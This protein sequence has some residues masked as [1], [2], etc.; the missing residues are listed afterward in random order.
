MQQHTLVEKSTGGT[1]TWRTEV[2]L[3]SEH[4]LHPT[5]PAM[6]TSSLLFIGHRCILRARGLDAILLPGHQS[7]TT[8][9]PH[10]W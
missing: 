9:Q 10:L 5:T 3:H 2:A 6:N 1:P 4:E 7:T 8:N